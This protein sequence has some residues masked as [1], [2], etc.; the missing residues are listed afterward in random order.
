M[1]KES[2]EILRKNRLQ[3]LQTDG[4]QSQLSNCSFKRS[5]SREK[6]CSTPTDCRISHTSNK[7]K[8]NCK[9]ESF[10]NLKRMESPTKIKYESSIGSSS[11]NG[12]MCYLNTEPNLSSVKPLFEKKRSIYLIN[13][14][15]F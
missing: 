5:Y 15:S 8:K 12:F 11:N 9:V 7:S 2:I 14:I 4:S 13:I 3:T 6:S 1:Q 10:T